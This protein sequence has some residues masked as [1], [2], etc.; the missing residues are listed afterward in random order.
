MVY[1]TIENKC[2]GGGGGDEEEVEKGI[3]GKEEGISTDLGQVG[4]W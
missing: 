1:W 2:G 3:K 4:L